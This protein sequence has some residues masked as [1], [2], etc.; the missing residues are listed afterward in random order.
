VLYFSTHQWPFYPGTGSSLETGHGAGVDCTINVPL[1]AGAGDSEY[2]K[3][4]EG[5]LRREALIFS[6]D[7]VFVSA[8]FDAHEGDTLGRMAV[9]TEGFA[10]LTRIVKEIAVQCCHGR[11][12][13]TLEGGYRLDDLAASVEAHL[14]VLME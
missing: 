11:L 13:A 3:V 12:V 8:G 6:P 14:R 4:F 7:F 5:K 9:T 10:K 1:P 2:T